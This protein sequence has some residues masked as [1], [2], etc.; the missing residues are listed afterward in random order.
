MQDTFVQ[1]IADT[2][3]YSS[4][5]ML[6]IY[7]VN[8]FYYAFIDYPQCQLSNVQYNIFYTGAT[9]YLLLQFGFVIN[10]LLLFYHPN[11]YSF[12]TTNIMDLIYTMVSVIIDTSLN[13]Y[14]LYSFTQSI[15]QL[16]RSK[17]RHAINRA[18]IVQETDNLLNIV[19]KYF[20]LLSFSISSSSIFLIFCGISYG[21]NLGKKDDS[22]YWYPSDHYNTF[23]KIPPYIWQI[24]CLINAYCIF[25][26]RDY[27]K[28]FYDCC[29]V[30]M[31]KIHIGI[32][33]R[34]RQLAQNNQPEQHEDTLLDH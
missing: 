2:L 7:F 15:I 10:M 27:T 12:K 29:C 28:K 32:K 21:Y 13:I 20:I 11:V 14:V 25:F 9:L 26:E 1:S 17:S 19:T 16:I 31:T 24:D 22:L 6:T 18:S 30:S 3:W 33:R 23:E 5:F 34:L 4:E 8:R